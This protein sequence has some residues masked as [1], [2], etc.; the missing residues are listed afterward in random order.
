MLLAIQL[1]ETKPRN[2]VHFVGGASEMNPVTGHI[3][4]RKGSRLVPPKDAS[5]KA[6]E[7]ALRPLEIDDT[8]AE[9]YIALALIETQYDWDW[10]GGES[11]FR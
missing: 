2:A 10:S 4:L 3:L 5:P 6:K 9:A 11:E 8:L 1:K 7:A